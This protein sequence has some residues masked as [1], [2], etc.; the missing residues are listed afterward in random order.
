MGTKILIK[1]LDSVE[2][3]NS[4][5]PLEGELVY[6]KCTNNLYVGDGKHAIEELELS[7]II[8]NI[9]RGQDDILY[10][11]DISNKDD[12]KIVP[13]EFY[14]SIAARQIGVTD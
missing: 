2:L 6:I 7:A 10:K 11:T 5:K 9:V 4:Y 3:S 1:R 12:I 8:I 13:L 14:S